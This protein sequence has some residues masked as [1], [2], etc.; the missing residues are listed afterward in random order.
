MGGGEGRGRAA[1]LMSR[2]EGEEE[3]E[4]PSML[5]PHQ[6]SSY[7]PSNPREAAPEPG[8]SSHKDPS[9]HTHTPH[10]PVPSRRSPLPASSQTPP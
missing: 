4:C 1:A 8:L 9:K 7:S 3:E 10:L 5:I 6:S 2:K